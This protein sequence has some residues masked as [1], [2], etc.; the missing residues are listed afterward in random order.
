MTQDSELPDLLPTPSQPKS[1]GF[2]PF[3]RRIDGPRSSRRDF[4]G[5]LGF[6]F[7]VGLGFSY[8]ALG[9]LLFGEGFS[10]GPLQYIAAGGCLLIAAYSFA[11]VGLGI[12]RRITVSRIKEGPGTPI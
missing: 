7:L 9:V 2:H 1:G 12:F 6:F 10:N 8:L 4:L 3:G 11:F 5:A